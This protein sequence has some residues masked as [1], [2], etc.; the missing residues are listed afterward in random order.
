MRG[1]QTACFWAALTLCASHKAV[2]APAISAK[3]SSRSPWRL[4]VNSACATSLPAANSTANQPGRLALS[5]V[6]MDSVR[7]FVHTGDPNH[8]TL[9]QTWQPWPRKF[10]FDADQKAARLS[11]Q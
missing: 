7:A 5:A 10:I 1:F 3:P 9:G 8:A 6:M 11:V 2:A 4:W